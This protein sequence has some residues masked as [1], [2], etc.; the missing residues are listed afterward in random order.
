MNDLQAARYDALA[1]SAEQGD[2]DE[3]E[4]AEFDSLEAIIEGCMTEEQRAHSGLILHV[5]WN[6]QLVATSGLIPADDL[7]AAH[8]AGLID[9]DTL[10]RYQ[11]RAEEVTAKTE[12]AKPDL[13]AALV[14]DLRA[15]RNAA[16]Q[17]KLI[18]KPDLALDLLAFTVLQPYGGP[19]GIRRDHSKIEPSVADGFTGEPRLAGTDDA[20]AEDFAAFRAMGKKHRNAVLAHA[21]AR[22]LKYGGSDDAERQEPIF[23]EIE[24]EVSA[25]IRDVWTPTAENFFGR[26]SGSYLENLLADLSGCARDSAEFKAFASMKKKEK[27]ETLERLFSDAETQ[28]LWKIDADKKARIAAWQPSGF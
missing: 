26:V 9:A 6:G 19:L 11:S 12:K 13:S 25:T 17:G 20:A 23:G 2:L 1:A 10:G 28:K 18:D 3:A 15:M 24:R 27:A 14:A 16:I 22:T 8:D 7:G 21:L 4:E 5:N